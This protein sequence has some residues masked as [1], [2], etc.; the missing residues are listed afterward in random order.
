MTW[1]RSVAWLLIVL[2]DI[3]LLAW[4]AMAAM[5]PDY[6]LGPGSAPI[7][8]AEYKTFTGGDW[9]ELQK[10]S[11][12]T[13][14]FIVILFRMYGVYIVAF[15]LLAIAIAAT[16]LRRREAWAW[17]MLLIGNSIAYISAM[18]FDWTVGAIGPLEMTEYLGLAAIYIAL[19]AT[20]PFGATRPAAAGQVRS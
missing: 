16:A 13:A 10:A 20:A 6:L 7:L 11:P 19:G 8:H 1:L 4:G 12:G 5:L 14:A 9:T 17:W 2:A 15:G 3:G 18:T